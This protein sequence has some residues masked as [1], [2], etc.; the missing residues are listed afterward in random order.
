MDD[1]NNLFEQTLLEAKT[2]ETKAPKSIFYSTPP[3]LEN[4][5]VDP[6]R[7]K[8]EDR[9]SLAY[10]IVQNKFI[11]ASEVASEKMIELLEAER[12]IQTKMGNIV[13]VPDAKVQLLAAKDILDRA[14]HGPVVKN[15][16][17]SMETNFSEDQAFRILSALGQS[18]T[19][20]E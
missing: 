2:V 20:S 10:N 3:S 8:V 19:M 14:G 18:T 5:L 4:K 16:N 13:Y 9:K 6:L 11:D 7:Q 17:L 15:I 1:L 12:P